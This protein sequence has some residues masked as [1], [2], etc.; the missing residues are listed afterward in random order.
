MP[1][2][3]DAQPVLCPHC[4]SHEF[5]VRGVVDYRQPYDGRKN[6][7]GVS[8]IFWD[9]DWPQY[10]ECAGCEHDVTALFK[11]ARIIEDFYKILRFRGGK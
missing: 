4:G 9:C 10:V 1:S 11:R 5:T 3:K 7:Y 2:R 8:K 6:E